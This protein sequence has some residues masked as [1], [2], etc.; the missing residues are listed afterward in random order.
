ML[1]S[2]GI[3]AAYGNPVASVAGPAAVP[4]SGDASGDA[5]GNPTRELPATIVEVCGLRFE[6][7]SILVTA[8]ATL[9]FGKWTGVSGPGRLTRAP[10]NRPTHHVPIL[11]MN[12]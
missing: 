10:L 11:V 7:G 3:H 9:P 6:R 4:W 1:K 8:N 2:L 12:G 5:S